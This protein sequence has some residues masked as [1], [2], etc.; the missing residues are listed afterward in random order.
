V[1]DLGVHLEPLL[2]CAAAGFTIQNLTHQGNRLLEEMDRVALPVYVI[3]FTMAGARLDL[4]AL[5]ATW[6]V[7]LVIAG[8]RVATMIVGARMA[9]SLAGD[10]P[11]FRRYCWLGFVTQAGLSLALIAQIESSY[12]DWGTQLATMLVAVVAINQ[13]VGPAA[14]KIALEEVGEVRQRPTGRRFSS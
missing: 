3:F 2:I 13:L 9:G 8:S 4:G 1:H 7:A 11:P 10:P 6:G 14:F 5:L 12:A